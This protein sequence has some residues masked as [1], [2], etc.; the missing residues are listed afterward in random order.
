MVGDVCRSCG[1]FKP[2]EGAIH[3]L[4]H[5]LAGTRVYALELNGSTV[6]VVKQVLLYYCI[7]EIEGRHWLACV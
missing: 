1:W 4:F 3:P 5:Y 7:G 2:G 6:A